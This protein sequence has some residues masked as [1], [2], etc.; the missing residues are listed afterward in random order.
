MDLGKLVVD[1][2]P[3]EPFPTIRLISRD[4]ESLDKLLAVF[5]DLAK[6]KTPEIDLLGLDFVDSGNLAGLTLK[7]VT[8]GREPS[9]AVVALEPL[10]GRPRFS[11]SRDAEGWLECAEK[12]S[13]M[14]EVDDAGQRRIRG[15]AQEL[16][17]GYNC[18]SVGLEWI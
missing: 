12:V 15:D 10:M 14:T 18:V 3:T 13:A 7:L 16:S 9:K 4:F 8:D 6:A 2:D 1:F 5:N 17:R 11:W